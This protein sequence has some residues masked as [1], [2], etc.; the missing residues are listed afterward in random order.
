MCVRV[1]IDLGLF[2]LIVRHDSPIS[3]EELAIRSEVEQ[4]LVGN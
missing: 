4:L 3:A 2:G 1:A